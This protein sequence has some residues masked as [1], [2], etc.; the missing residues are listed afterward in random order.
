MTTKRGK[1]PISDVALADVNCGDGPWVILNFCSI[2]V[3]K[4]QGTLEISIFGLCLFIRHLY[5]EEGNYLAK[6]A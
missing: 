3:R 5:L 1:T 2:S 6:D 4:S